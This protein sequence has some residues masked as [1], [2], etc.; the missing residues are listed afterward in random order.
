MS[1]SERTD[2]QPP[3]SAEGAA[4]QPAQARG[5]GARP[6][7]VGTLLTIATGLW[8]VQVEMVLQTAEVSE[9]VPLIPAIAGLLVLVLYNRGLDG[10]SGLLGRRAPGAREWLSRWRL[11]RR[12]IIIVYCFMTL[13]ALMMSAKVAG[14][15][16]PETTVYTYFGF[17]NANFR[18]ASEHMPSWLILQDHDVVRTLYEGGDLDMPPEIGGLPGALARATEGLWWPLMQVPWAAWVPLLAVWIVIMGLVFTAGMCLLGLMKR[19]W[20]EKERLSFPLVMIP[21]EL[22]SAGAT[23][24]RSAYLRDA[25]FWIGFLLSGTFTLFV[26]LHAVSPGLPQFQPYYN[27]AP[28]FSDH[29]WRSVQ[30]ASIQVRPELVG[31]SYFMDSDILLTMWVMTFVNSFLAVGTAA[32]GYETRDFPRPFDQGV[33]SYVVL[34]IFFVWSARTWLADGIGQALIW[35]TSREGKRYA[36]LWGGLILSVGALIAIVIAAGM[37]WWVAVYLFT[38]I[39]VFFLVYG[40]ARAETGVPHPSPFPSGGH[41]TVLEYIAGPKSWAGGATPGLLGSFFFLSRGY[42]LTAAGAEIENLK[43]ADTEGI[44]ERSMIWMSLIAPV[45]GLA[46]AFTLRLGAGYHFGLNFLEGG[47][48]EGGYAITQMRNHADQVIREATTGVGRT[49]PAANA[50]IFGGI[51][52]VALIVLRR[53]FLRF[54]LHPLGYGLAMVRL[55]AFWA[56]IMLT[57]LIKTLLLKIGGARAY[58]RAAPAFM[59][60][61]IGHYF[62]AG[63]CLGILGATYPQMLDK[64]EVINF[65]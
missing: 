33:G 62:F 61:A 28:L 49:V 3:V 48:V 64:I 26:V 27:L 23:G 19:Y 58:R 40:R 60:L 17:D 35:R 53:V 44:R 24:R 5:I 29:P 10:L 57:W 11:S 50:A 65:D 52:T 37:K 25:G 32:A 38:I 54:P 1:A 12:E 21:L 22:S 41:L 34:A 15:I 4:T 20:V 42:T 18:Q 6:I 51:V 13:S 39:L 46:I 31:M 47:T 56:P 63:I 45:I 30:N 55:R 36:A 16:I 59:G 8:V 14:Y 7:I 2:Q 43:I 9:S